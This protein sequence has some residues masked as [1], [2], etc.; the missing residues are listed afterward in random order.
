MEFAPK[1][2]GWTSGFWPIAPPQAYLASI[3]RH[4]NSASLS[5]HLQMWCQTLRYVKYIITN[6][7]DW[8][9][10]L[11]HAMSMSVNASFHSGRGPEGISGL[12]RAGRPQ[13]PEYLRRTGGAAWTETPVGKGSGG[14][15]RRRSRPPQVVLERTILRFAFGTPR[16]EKRITGLK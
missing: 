10:R 9:E 11:Q 2:T 14:S 3:M 5:R 6:T 13:P 15:S 1:E 8:S 12:R 7:S 16:L 4:T